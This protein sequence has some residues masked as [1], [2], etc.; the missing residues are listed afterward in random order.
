MRNEKDNKSIEWYIG[1][2]SKKL[3]TSDGEAGI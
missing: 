3:Y 1:I 2:F